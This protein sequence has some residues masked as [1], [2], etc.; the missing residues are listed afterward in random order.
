MSS[1][2]QRRIRYVD[3]VASALLSTCE[4][5]LQQRPTQIRRHI[6]VALFTVAVF[7]CTLVRRV[8]TRRRVVELSCRYVVVK[9]ELQ[10]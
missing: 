5:P 8:Q 10:A 2:E 6:T 3:P 7:S 4:V 1:M 9:K